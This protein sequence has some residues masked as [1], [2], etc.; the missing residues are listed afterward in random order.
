[1]KPSH[2]GIEVTHKFRSKVS[3]FC[4]ALWFNIAA[5]VSIAATMIVL[6]SLPCSVVIHK[7]ACF[8][9]FHYSGPL[10]PTLVPPVN[11]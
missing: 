1:M 2:R 5:I 7:D 4:D 9:R 11:A 3:L 8:N 6:K 10:T